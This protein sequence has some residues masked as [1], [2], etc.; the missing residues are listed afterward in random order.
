M[1]AR[2]IQNMP[3]GQPKPGLLR[4]A[5]ERSSTW[6]IRWCGWRARS[7]GIFWTGRFASVCAREPVIPAYDAT[8][9]R[10]GFRREQI[11]YRAAPLTTKSA[12]PGA[13]RAAQ[14]RCALCAVLFQPVRT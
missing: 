11:F 1:V 2:L 5:L 10:A 13:P 9:G 4:P 8:G 6:A 3:G 12:S 14:T 7:V